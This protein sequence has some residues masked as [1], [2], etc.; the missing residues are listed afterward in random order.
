MGVHARGAREGVTR[1]ELR[2]KYRGVKLHARG[3]KGGE[4]QQ[5]KIS[6]R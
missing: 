4:E 6:H 1:E 3:K 5:E 2:R